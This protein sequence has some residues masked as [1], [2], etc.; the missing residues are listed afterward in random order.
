MT[1]FRLNVFFFL[2]QHL[3]CAKEKKKFYTKLPAISKSPIKN[4]ICLFVA[5]IIR[6]LPPS[7]RQMRNNTT[8]SF[9][10][11]IGADHSEKHNYMIKKILYLFRVALFSISLINKK[12]ICFSFQL[13]V[14]LFF[15]P[16]FS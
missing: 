12:P 16:F 6:Q 7:T 8:L 14:V 13:R 3:F 15:I 10:V 4:N 2:K 1:N 9:S 11:I 5:T